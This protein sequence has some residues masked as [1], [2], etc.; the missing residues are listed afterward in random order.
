MILRFKNVLLETGASNGI[1]SQNIFVLFLV[2]ETTFK[3]FSVSSRTLCIYIYVPTKASGLSTWQ[4][5]CQCLANKCNDVVS[6][7]DSRHVTICLGCD[8]LTSSTPFFPTS[9]VTQV[10]L[11]VSLFNFLIHVTISNIELECNLQMHIQF[12]QAWR[13]LLHFEHKYFPDEFL[14]LSMPYRS[15]CSFI[16]DIKPLF[17]S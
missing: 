1:S 6:S 8:V 2:K 12:K 14:R 11:N 7:S 16:A 4:R 3:F 5:W 15:C 10:V 9:H 17:Q 13:S